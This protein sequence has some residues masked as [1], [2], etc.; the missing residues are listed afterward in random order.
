MPVNAQGASQGRGNGGIIFMGRYEIQLL[1]SYN[2]RTYADGMAASIYGEW[3]PLVNVARKPGE[4]QSIDI[5][6]E[7]PRF[8]GSSHR[9]ISRCSGMAASC[10]TVQS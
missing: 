10:I 2:N 1:D 4:W 7:A 9:A 8:P 3:P 6:F 5:V